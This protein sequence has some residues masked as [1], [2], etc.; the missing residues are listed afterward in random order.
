M[1]DKKVN[2]II[3]LK[4][5]LSAGLQSIQSKTFSLNSAFKTLGA[6]AATYLS[7]RAVVGGIKSVIS[8][9]AE[10]ESV[11]AKLAATFTA[12]GENG[13]LAAAKW[14]AFATSIQRVTTYSDEDIMSLISLGKVMGITNDKLADAT[15][16]AIGLSKA[17]GL[18]LN[19]A[20]KMVALAGE[21][22]YEMLGRYIP[23]LRSAKT[24]AEKL[25]IVQ[26]AMATGFTIAKE[27]TKTLS[28]ATKSLQEV[29]GDAKEEIGKGATESGKL[30][31]HIN[32]LKD[33][34]VRLSE[35]G[36]LQEW[37]D[38]LGRVL[39]GVAKTAEGL[40]LVIGKIVEGWTN[41][42]VVYKNFMG[43]LGRLGANIVN[44]PKGAGSMLD[45]IKSSFS[46]S[47]DDK[48]F[49]GAAGA[50]QKQTEGSSPVKVEVTNTDD[51]AKSMGGG[52]VKK[53]QGG[54][55]ELYKKMSATGSSEYE[56][57]Q[58]TRFVAGQENVGS[59]QGVSGAGKYAADLRSGGLSEYDVIQ[60]VQDFIK[61]EIRGMQAGVSGVGAYATQLAA[62]GA[63]S[64]DINNAVTGMIGQ[65]QLGQ[66]LSGGLSD[67]LAKTNE[68][69]TTQN[70]MLEVIKKNVGGV[71]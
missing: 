60:K 15:K 34:I 8:A 6:T 55:A 24:E 32:K 23:E 51:I 69:L 27:E 7:F 30:T 2:V 17:F 42:G 10:A 36:S 53:T 14:G 37:G 18:D 62:S 52:D 44:P 54:F 25:T 49:V 46:K 68:L 39:N 65:E 47:E 28:G 20:M 11:S 3:A 9:Y 1:A 26:K 48:K 50:V 43:G 45:I 57:E 22:Q 16:G 59:K 33:A 71:E 4:D 13:T 70:E 66:G 31:E 5:Q 40:G 21:G 35:D 58:F 67:P 63:G 38:N 56:K 29:W 61:A 41:L 12:L 19:S 64:Y